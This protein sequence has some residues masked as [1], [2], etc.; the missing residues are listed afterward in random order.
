MHIHDRSM[1]IQA[2]GFYSAAQQERTAAASRAAEVRKKLLRASHSIEEDQANLFPDENLLIGHWLNAHH[3]P[4][5]D[6]EYTP[7]SGRN[8]DFV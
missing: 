1:T 3:S 6:D 5:D 2:M 8:P 4:L 7:S